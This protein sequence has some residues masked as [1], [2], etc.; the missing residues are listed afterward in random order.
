MAKILQIT[1]KHWQGGR[2]KQAGYCMLADKITIE[3]LSVWNTEKL[4]IWIVWTAHWECIHLGHI[5]STFFQVNLNQHADAFICSMC[6]IP[7]GCVFIL[8]FEYADQLS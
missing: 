8:S 3:M 1:N 6:G 4:I 7:E 5:P 2:L